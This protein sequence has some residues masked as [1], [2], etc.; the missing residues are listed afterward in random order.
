MD[1]ARDPRWG[2]IA[3]GFGEDPYMASV[4]AAAMVHGFQGNDLS[5]PNTIAACAKHF[6]GYGAAEGGLQDIVGNVWEWCQDWY[7]EDYYAHSGDVRNPVGPEKG[8]SR[9]FR[10]GSWYHEV[11]ICRCGYRYRFD[12][13]SWINDGGFRCARTLSS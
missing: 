9:V 1:I 11:E 12:P 13:R 4:M 7:A 5:A 6:V 3:E 2:R 10:G 8:V